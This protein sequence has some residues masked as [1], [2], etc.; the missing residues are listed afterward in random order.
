MQHFTR[1]RFPGD[2]DFLEHNVGMQMFGFL[3]PLFFT[4][5]VFVNSMQMNQTGS[6]IVWGTFLLDALGNLYD[7]L[8]NR[9]YKIMA[10]EKYKEDEA[11][12]AKIKLQEYIQKK[13]EKDIKKKAKRQ[14]SLD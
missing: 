7:A 2:K 6:E 10:Y 14:N 5:I 11:D 8:E 3:T 12:E 1:G 9:Q 13:M 4:L